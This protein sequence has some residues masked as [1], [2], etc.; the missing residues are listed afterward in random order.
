[1]YGRIALIPCTYPIAILIGYFVSIQVAGIFPVIIVPVV[2]S[3]ARVFGSMNDK[4]ESTN[5]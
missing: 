5:F 3:L 2:I 1:M 4:M